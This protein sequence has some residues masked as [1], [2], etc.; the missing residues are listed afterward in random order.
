MSVKFVY[1]TLPDKQTAISVARSLLGERLIACANI[2]GPV[3]SL[4]H[5]K[6]KPE[7]AEEYVLIAKTSEA[8]SNE[9]IARVKALHPY[10]CPAILCL[11]VEAGY[12]PFLDWVA[13]EVK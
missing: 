1:I 5:W 4:F 13:E 7:E 3:A 2:H 9:V 12:T 11:P 10:E 6:G 8:R